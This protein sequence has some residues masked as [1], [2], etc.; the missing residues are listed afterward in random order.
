MIFSHL[1]PKEIPTVVSRKEEAN[2]ASETLFFLPLVSR[3]EMDFSLSVFRVT[4]VSVSVSEKPGPVSFF[5][6]VL[7]FTP[8]SL[9]LTLSVS[10]FF[11]LEPNE[12]QT[13]V[14]GLTRD[15]PC[16]AFEKRQNERKRIHT[17]ERMR[18]RPFSF[19][20]LLMNR[21]LHPVWCFL[22]RERERQRERERI[23]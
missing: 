1:K 9:F 15:T 20:P 14:S 7:F 13:D 18:E 16:D 2:P 10:L 22:W 8:G 21:D 4:W 12:R 17:G 6:S 11:L 23:W 19:H 5:P 3:L